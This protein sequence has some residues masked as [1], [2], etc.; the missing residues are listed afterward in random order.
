MLNKDMAEAARKALSKPAPYGPDVDLSKYDVLNP[1]RIEPAE[2]LEQER[3]R[4]ASG[5]LGF[6]PEIV[7]KAGYV[8]VNEAYLAS[9]LVESLR[10]Q[11]VIVMSTAEALRKL[12]I[13]REVA[14]TLIR[15]DTD[16][17]VATAY[18]YGREQGYFI[19]V[20]PGVKVRTP[21]Y[22]CLLITRGMTAQLLHNIIYV[23]DGAE[24]NVVTGCSIAGLHAEALHIGVSE[25]FVGKDAKLTFAMIH[26]WSKGAVVRPRTAVK[27]AEGGRYV[28]YYMIYSAVHSLQSYPKVILGRNASTSLYSIISGEGEGIYDVGSSATL[29]APGSSAEIISRNLAKG[30]SR[31]VARAEIVGE[32]GP[33][34]GH[35][36]CMGL[37]LSDTAYISTVPL[38]DS[39]NPEATLT[40]EAAIGKIGEDQLTY[41]MSKGFSEEEARALIIRGFLSVEAPDLPPQVKLSVDR[42]TELISSKGHG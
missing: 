37:I 33:S 1:R 41:L 42:V 38:L 13:A 3:V 30:R 15:P 21:I 14:W 4:D 39:R 22:T 12:D 34:K 29:A 8:Q 6:T 7:R 24:A 32:S 11:G 23:A 18:L 26:A 17:Y 2:I 16:K 40:H 28:S 20:P 35:I 9:A 27:V 10:K 25:F 36:E 5:R 19:Y 31:V